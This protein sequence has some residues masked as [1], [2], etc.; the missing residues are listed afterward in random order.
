MGKQSTAC[1]SSARI[2]ARVLRGCAGG[3]RGGA[4]VL[5]RPAADGRTGRARIVAVDAEP[6]GIRCIGKDACSQRSASAE[7]EFPPHIHTADSGNACSSSPLY[8][9]CAA[10]AEKV[11]FAGQEFLHFPNGIVESRLDGPLG[12]SQV[13][14]DLVDLHILVVA[15]DDDLA[16]RGGKLAQGRNKRR[17]GHPGIQLARVFVRQRSL[18][19]DQL[20]VVNNPFAV[21][22]VMAGEVEKDGVEPRVNA[23]ATLKSVNGSN[24]LKKCL[25]ND[26]LGVGLIDRKS[27]V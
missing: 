3:P 14:G 15:Q 9:L 13:R 2:R 24:G 19:A 22:M 11:Q 25:L 6:A 20:V 27:V 7:K 5:R 21:S 23:R 8:L 16:V 26:V 10:G 4:R 12:D 18:P 17:R 1:L